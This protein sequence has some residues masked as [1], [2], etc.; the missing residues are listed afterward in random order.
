MSTEKKSYNEHCLYFTANSLARI[1]TEM[2]ER[3]FS[4]MGISAS[5]GHLMLII[6]D[7][8]DLSLS[9][10]SKQMHVKPSTMTRFID[11]LEHLGFVKRELVGRTASVSATKQGNELRLQIMDALKTLYENYCEV[12]GKD[13]A[14]KLTEN[15]HKANE[16]LYK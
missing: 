7:N 9:E 1:I 11:K 16:I 14:M 10:L 5:Y 12:L 15:T 3:A 13:F 2:T 6:I 8:P 4:K